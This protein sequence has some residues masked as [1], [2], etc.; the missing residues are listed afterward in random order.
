MHNAQ[1]VQ[2][3][4]VPLAFLFAAV[5]AL[6]LQATAS[7]GDAAASRAC[8]LM[9]TQELA[10]AFGAK[11]TGFEGTNPTADDP[12]SRC[13]A[14]VG[15]VV[16]KIQYGKPGPPLPTSVA[17]MLQIAREMESQGE[18]QTNAEVHSQTFGSVGCMAMKM[19]LVGWSTIC[20]DPKVFISLAAAR[21]GSLPVDYA[22]V[23]KLL[24]A[25][26]ARI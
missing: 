11:P 6:T 25:A 2:A 18:A 17:E 4:S 15:D 20:G 23:R 1:G 26:K 10:R 8:G 22:T 19:K 21:A 9:P 12:L 3:A 16:V 24:A 5:A 14:H 13:T 7:A